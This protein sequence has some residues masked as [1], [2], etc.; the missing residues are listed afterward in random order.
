MSSQG[1]GEEGRFVGGRSVGPIPLL[2]SSSLSVFLFVACRGHASTEDCSAMT[3]HYLDLAV[4]DTPGA[5]AMSSAQAAA[6]RDVERGVKRAEPSYRI[7]Q[8]H[9]D[10]LTRSQVS[11]ALDAPTTR[12]WEACVH[13]ADAR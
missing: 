3:E 1:G 9:C 12:A 11:C 10:W 6:V 4:K 5:A 7:V 13:P 8:D 2:L